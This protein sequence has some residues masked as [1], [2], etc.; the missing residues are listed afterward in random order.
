MKKTAKFGGTSLA[1][2][3]RFLLVRDIV[4]SDPDIHFIVVSAPGKRF[5]GDKKITDLLY[6]CSSLLQDGVTFADAFHPVANRFREIIDELGIVLDIER[7]FKI[8]ETELESGA[9]IDYCVSRGE[10]F[11]ALILAELLGWPV[12][13]PGECVFF[14]HNRDAN[15]HMATETLRQ[16]SA[17]LEYAVMPGFYGAMKDGEICVFDRGGSDI[18]GAILACATESDIYENWT[19]VPGV[20]NADP[21]I[22]PDA[23]VI[24]SMTYDEIRELAYMGANVL[25]ESAVIPVRYLGIPIHMRY[26]MNKSVPGTLISN[27]KDRCFNIVTGISGRVGY[28]A[29][30]IEKEEMNSTV[31]YC[32]RILSA[33]EKN[34]VPFDH[35]ATGLGSISLIAPTKNIER[36][37]DELIMDINAAV[38]PSSISIESGLAM[39]S[40][41]GDCLKGRSGIAGRLLGAIGRAGINIRM[42]VQGTREINITIGINENDYEEAVIS[43]HSEFFAKKY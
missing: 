35:I 36:C 7:E 40:V 22:I 34:D 33:F 37:R 2:A 16:R 5:D 26:T 6:E 28:S 38:N 17:N 4:N 25:H 11:S 18:S 3:G 14:D 27:K 8:M 12:I 41:V 20:F 43:A 21:K 1:D 24:P 23:A 10:Y 9:S 29:V 13:E 32:R 31:G 42:I 19:D 15:F 30:Q 39:V